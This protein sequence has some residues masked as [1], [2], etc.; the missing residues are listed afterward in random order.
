MFTVDVYNG[1]SFQHGSRYIKYRVHV[2][3]SDHM[4]ATEYIPDPPKE[5]CS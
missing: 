4:T 3:V 1:F 2:K 5:G